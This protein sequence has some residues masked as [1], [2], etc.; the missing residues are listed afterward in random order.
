MLS[1]HNAPVLAAATPTL[2]SHRSHL[3]VDVTGSLFGCPFCTDGEACPFHA[4]RL[5]PSVNRVRWLRTHTLAEQRDLLTRYAACHKRRECSQFP[6]LRA[7]VACPIDFSVKTP[8]AP[9]RHSRQRNGHGR[10]AEVRADAAASEARH[11]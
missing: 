10:L 4:I 1:P 6:R 3:P 11:G 2:T 9:L 7:P 8:S 5:D